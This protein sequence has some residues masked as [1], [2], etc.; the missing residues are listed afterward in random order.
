LG[1]W[2]SFWDTTNQ[3]AAAINT[4]YAI[5]INSADPLNSGVSVAS[6]SQITFAYTGVY[7]LTF[8]IQFTNTS[9]ANGSTQIWLK[10]N[11]TNL[12]DT[13]SHYD[14]PDKQGSSFSSE[15]LTVN[16]VLS[17]TATDYIQV[18][19]QTA[20]TSV[21]IETLA[22]SG[23]YPRT[24]SIIFTAT[25]VMYTQLGPTGATGSVGAVGPTGPTGAASTVA[26]PTGAAGATGP[27]GP[28]GPGTVTSVD[29]SAPAIFTVSG[30]PITTSGTLALTYSGTA[31]PILNGGTGQTTAN[32]AFNALAPSQTSQSGKYLTT[33]G[34]N[35]SWSA[36]GGTTIT[37]SND[38][39]TSTAVYPLFSAATS[40]TASTVYTGN[41]YY[42]YTPSTGEL[43]AKEMVS[44]NGIVVNSGTV[45]TSYTIATGN[46][47]FSV[48]PI[49]INSGVTLTV[50]S[51]QR[52][53]VI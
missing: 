4:P 28:T 19:W 16:F 12:A 47:G 37:I 22:A 42:L 18:F 30:N 8:S 13:S 26:G 35:T 46:N 21:T 36:V 45:S 44:T 52:Y 11:G 34:T 48:G 7:S 51:G 40:G 38:T 43:Q 1:Y 15:I 33:D 5:T 53:I 6:S 27:T 9:T 14:V 49:T 2:G 32:T 3:S 20:N 23:G 17:L 10:K 31:L 25:Q 24:P 50:A 39:A 29:L 41:A